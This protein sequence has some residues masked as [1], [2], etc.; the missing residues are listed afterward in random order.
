MLD[1]ASPRLLKWT[2][3][4]IGAAGVVV[5]TASAVDFARWPVMDMGGIVARAFILG[6]LSAQLIPM[7]GLPV[8][9]FLRR[10]V[11]TP[12]RVLFWSWVLLSVGILVLGAAGAMAFHR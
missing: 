7:L 2:A 6:L 10:P 9:L 4:V 11:A 8:A 3:V 12:G 1:G 5:A